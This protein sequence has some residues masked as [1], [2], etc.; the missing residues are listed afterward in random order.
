MRLLLGFGVGF[1]LQVF[2]VVLNAPEGQIHEALALNASVLFF[3]PGV[4]VLVA[5]LVPP[6]LWGAYHYLIPAIH[7]KK[8]ML[9]MVIVLLLHA[10]SALWV[11][12]TDWDTVRRELMKPNFLLIAGH[13]VVAA[14][15]FSGLIL[16]TLFT[17]ARH[18]NAA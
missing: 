13:W 16:L 2:G 17:G 15:A 9:I 8:R 12:A 18:D 3:I 7:S 6:V 4:G 14:V 1:L 11:I 10:A 5:V